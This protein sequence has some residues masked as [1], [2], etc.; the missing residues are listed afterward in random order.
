MN[1]L[2]FS[3]LLV[4]V[5]PTVH[6]SYNINC[7]IFYIRYIKY[8]K[9]IYRHLAESSAAPWFFFVKPKPLWY[10]I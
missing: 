4:Y 9:M 2:Q 8:N 5:S 1:Q 3:K 7:F 6:N 10:F